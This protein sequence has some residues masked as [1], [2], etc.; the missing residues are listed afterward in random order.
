MTTSDKP[1]R[2]QQ[3]L[4]TLAHELETHPGSRITTASLA[5]AVGVSEAALYRHFASKAKMFEALI[6]FAEESV[7]GLISKIMAQETAP[8][9]RCEKIL[10][11][12]LGFAERN[13]GITRVLLGEALVGENERLRSRVSQ[14]FERIRTQL[15]QVLRE[16]NL[17]G[18]ARASISI[19]AAVD[20][21]LALVEGH[22]NQY[23]RSGFSDRPTAHWPEQWP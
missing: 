1:N 13:P 8:D 7:F 3:I 21:L 4:E 16:A 12:L 18:G 17:A 23:A 20:V 14:F 19:D 6:D 2:R 5:R 22:M 15:K 10:Q 9:V 11:L